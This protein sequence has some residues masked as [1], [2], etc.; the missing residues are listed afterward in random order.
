M[1]IRPL[2]THVLGL[3]AALFVGLC[4]APAGAQDA[5]SLLSDFLHY[6]TIDNHELAGAYGS[7]LLDDP[8]APDEFAALVE[9]SG[10]LDR[11][12]DVTRRIQ[13][14]PA[15]AEIGGGLQARYQEGKLAQARNPAQIEESIALLGQ[16]GRATLVAR[17]RLSEAGEYAMPYLLPAF[18]QQGDVVLQQEV[19]RVLVEMGSQAIIPLVTALPHVEPTLQERIVGVLGQISYPT[20]VPFLYD[21]A[22]STDNQRVG[23]ACERAIDRIGAGFNPDGDV[24]SYYE[25]LAEG[26][27]AESGS[28]TSFPGESQQLLW[29]YNPAIGLTPQAIPT[30]LFHEAMCMALTERAMQLRPDNA[31]ALALWLSANFSREIDDAGRGMPNP[32]YGDD[33]REAKY[34]AVASGPTASQRV[35]RRALDARDTALAR[36]AIEAIGATAGGTNLWDG[37]GERRPLLEALLYGNRRVRYEA[38][39]ALAE[40]HPRTDFDGANRVVPL[41]AGA[42]R[43]ASATYA[44][45]V[46]AD[47]ERQQFLTD[48]LRGQGMTVLPTGSSL[49]ALN[50]TISRAPGVDLIVT[51]LLG[52]ETENL[53]ASARNDSRLEAA[54]IVSLLDF[55]DLAELQPRFATVEGITLLRSGVGRSGVASA[56]EQAIEASLG[57][58]LSPTEAQAYKFRSLKALRDL[59]VSASSVLDVADATDALVG[60][61]DSEPTEIGVLIAEILSYVGTSEAQQALAEAAL[62]AVGAEQVTL[63]GSLAGS[64]RRFGDQL[65]D[66]QVR[67]LIG[68][69]MD[70]DERAATG[71]ATVLG[72]LNLENRSVLPLILDR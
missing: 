43:D 9:S 31:E 7:A 13:G 19:G 29:G 18:A 64:V 12:E 54:P 8:M 65:E 24:S 23:N 15:L 49:G 39:L 21:L 42:V 28:L 71:A 45:V 55:A 6:A 72:A 36:R 35:L 61:M 4:S 20:S 68:L 11:F 16:G 50:E 60:A 38:A 22:Q 25:A 63:L 66:A 2:R 3:L 14:V 58:S 30:E 33:R 5:G 10:N 53:I 48:A 70:S 26:Y 17:R 51:D 1:S 37:L 69:S 59:S 47:I 52:A 34:Y 32:S 46:A 40:A 67:R 44:L 56:S 41:L 62:D 57:G 27:Y